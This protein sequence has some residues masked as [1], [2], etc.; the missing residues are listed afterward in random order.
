M[1]R[2]YLKQFEETGLPQTEPAPE[3]KP[4]QVF[5]FEVVEHLGVLS[6]NDK[7]WQIEVNRTSYNGRAPKLDIRRISPNGKLGK[8]IALNAQEEDA[9]KQILLEK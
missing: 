3:N 1:D 5:T 7:G 4:S 8:G 9:L 6:T 2:D